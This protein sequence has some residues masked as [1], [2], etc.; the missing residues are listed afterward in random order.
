MKRPML[1]S[2]ITM[3]VICALLNILP[4]SVPIVIAL[5][6]SAFVL[7]LILKKAGKN[8]FTLSF[9]CVC[10]LIITCVFSVFTITKVL[11]CTEL[12]NTIA[13]VEGKVI[14]SPKLIKDTWVFTVKTRKINSL[15]ADHNITVHYAYNPSAP[16]KLYDYILLGDAKLSVP[17]DDRNNLITGDIADGALLCA[18]PERIVYLKAAPKTPYYYCLLLKQTVTER[19]KHSMTDSNGGLLSG[20]LFGEKAE[21]NY[22]TA[23]AFRN[24]GIAHLLAV[25]GL[26][27]ALWC[28]L[29]LGFL[30]LFK[31]NDKAGI[32]ICTVFLAG[33]CAVS[34]FTPSVI[35]ASLMTVCAFLAP[36]FKRRSDSFN[37]LGLAVTILLI[38]NPYTVQSISFQLSVAATIGVLLASKYNEKLYTLCKSIPGKRTKGFCLYILSSIVISAFSGIC[39]L[40]VSAYHFGVMGI[41][42]PIANILCVKPAFWGMISGTSATALSLIPTVI[43]QIIARPLFDVTEFILDI[44]T[45]LATKISNITICTLPVHKS[46]LI[47]GLALGFIIL[48]TGLI[49]HKATGKKLII[50]GTAIAMVVVILVCILI[51]LVSP[52][53]KNTITVVSAGNSLHIILRSGLRYAYI[54]NATTQ[55]PSQIHKYLPKATSESLDYFVA[56]YLTT[57]NLYTLESIGNSYSPVE[58]RI[59]KEIN[60]LA[61]TNG[62]NL[63]PNT[64]IETC[65][66]FTLSPEI[67]FEIIDTYPTQY[68]IIKGNEKTVYVHLHGD[69]SLSKVTNTDNADIFVFNGDVPQ[70]IQPDLDA[71]IIS[72]DSSH[73]SSIN[74]PYL[75]KQC[76]TLHFTARDGDIQINI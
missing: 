49:F 15:E 60:R 2:G 57:T 65:G 63:P 62:I 9:I 71:I 36:Q 18:E 8:S 5:G 10:T 46:G 54:T 43:T 29:L 7:S 61:T 34:A 76:D 16:V 66:K 17:A 64:F 41:L 11:P 14:T 31:A 68:V 70:V 35:R 3:T 6:A 25:S 55:A 1:I 30:K 21:M 23:K 51:P 27:T 73:I 74:T 19:I 75:K 24:S 28:S 53:H 67:T 44:V 39:T 20:M 58:T 42:S 22:N 33:F 48:S 37:S 47:V 52:K 40:P 69:T 32:I 13:Q 4:K 72:G 12:N 26:H 59:T 45:A 38:I 56:T 50:K